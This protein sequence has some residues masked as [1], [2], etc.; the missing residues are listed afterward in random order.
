FRITDLYPGRLYNI[1]VRS[2]VGAEESRE[3]LANGGAGQ[4]TTPSRPGKLML[5]KASATWSPYHIYITWT[6]STSENGVERY[7]VSL[8]SGTGSIG[9]VEYSG[10]RHGVNITNLCPGMSYCVRV[11]AELRNLISPPSDNCFS[12]VETRPSDAPTNLI[13][14]PQRRSLIV[15]FNTL[16]RPNGRITTYECYIHNLNTSTD[17]IQ[18]HTTARKSSIAVE[19]FIIRDLEPY[20]NYSIRVRAYTSVGSGPWSDPVSEC[21][22]EAAPGNVSSFSAAPINYTT[23]HLTW[24]PPT[25][26]NGIIREYVIVNPPAANVRV[27]STTQ[28]YIVTGLNGY[29]HYTFGIM[30]V[31]VEVGNEARISVRTPEGRKLCWICAR[32]ILLYI[33]SNL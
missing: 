11:V 9:Q 8:T 33:N 29:T 30:A 28:E 23:V 15:I 19:T 6:N 17:T 26:R 22:L 13:L 12:T 27:R 32:L 21:T 4:L 24:T 14:I 31:T 3:V 16:R 5:E 20:T 18:N 10:N 25:K 2:I 1:S 7:S